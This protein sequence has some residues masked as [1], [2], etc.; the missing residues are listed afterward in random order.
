M[1]SYEVTYRDI[2][3]AEYW[4][5]FMFLGVMC[6]MLLNIFAAFLERARPGVAVLDWEPCLSCDGQELIRQ[7]FCVLFCIYYHFLNFHIWLNEVIVYNLDH[8]EA[9]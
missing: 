6:G 1:G 3:T 9:L 8:D 5:A 7:L 4:F 2:S